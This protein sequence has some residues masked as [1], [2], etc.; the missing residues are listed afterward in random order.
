MQQIVLRD[1]KME[2]H[3][4]YQRFAYVLQDGQEVIVKQV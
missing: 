2:V 4:L 3:A 1:V